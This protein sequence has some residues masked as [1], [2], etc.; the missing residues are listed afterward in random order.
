MREMI[1][2]NDYVS[3]AQHY[4]IYNTKFLSICECALF[5]LLFFSPTQY[6][7]Q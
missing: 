1:V 5:L 2:I 3:P 7:E 4:T 6:T